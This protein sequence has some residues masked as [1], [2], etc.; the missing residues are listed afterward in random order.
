MVQTLVSDGPGL[1][2][3]HARVLDGTQVWGTGRGESPGE[4]PEEQ[5]MQTLCPRLPLNPS[6]R[7]NRVGAPLDPPWVKSAFFFLGPSR[8]AMTPQRFCFYL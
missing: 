4:G 3:R 5:S 7:Q 8:Q 1:C 6:S 2:P